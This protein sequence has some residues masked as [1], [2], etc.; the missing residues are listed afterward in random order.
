MD[1]S[2]ATAPSVP[3]PL[4][5]GRGLA[6]LV[7]AAAVCV[8]GGLMLGEYEFQGVLPYAAGLL[9]GLVI[10][11]IIAEVGQVRSWLMAVLSAPLVAGGLGLAVRISTG[12]GLE[13]MPASGWAA[14]VLG[15]ACVAW[16][17]GPWSVRSRPHTG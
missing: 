3:E 14:M 4:I 7:A 6:A 8:L 1:G 11:E 15:A 13:P 5:T 9:F 16:R 10:G 17:T 12:E 2:S